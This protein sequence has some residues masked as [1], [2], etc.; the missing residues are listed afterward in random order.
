MDQESYLNNLMKLTNQARELNEALK[1]STTLLSSSSSV[2]VDKIE[3]VSEERGNLN[4]LTVLTLQR[5]LSQETIIKL[6]TN[7]SKV[8]SELEEAN[9]QKVLPPSCRLITLERVTTNRSLCYQ[10]HTLTLPAIYIE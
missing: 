7:L 6:R 2:D 3:Q 9:F 8:Q 1:G 5:F 10:L 4:P